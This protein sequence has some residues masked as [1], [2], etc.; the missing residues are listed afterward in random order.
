LI[1]RGA[2]ENPH[3]GDQRIAGELRKL[4]ISISASTVRRVQLR[5]R[6]GPAPRR[7]GPS[8]RQC[9]RQ[10]AASIM[11]CDFFCV[12]TMLLRRIYVLFFIELGTRR[13]HLAGLTARPTGAW[14]AQQARNLSMSGVLRQ[15]RFLIRDRDSKYTA[16]F[17]TI[18]TNE[19]LRVIRTPMRTP[20]AN[21][22][23]ERFVR[24][25]RNECLDW[26]L[27]L[28]QRQLERVLRTYI[29]QYSEQ[30]HRA[31]ELRPPTPTP[32]PP[33]GSIRR[34]DQLGGLIHEY[35]RAAT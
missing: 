18:F 12:E 3:W 35:H 4:G 14:V 10:Q 27:I 15:M 25:V 16:A 23:A 31:L 33:I 20:V 19:G 28:N 1:L 21:A 11:A 24:T 26:L 22:Y 6:L 30:P 9:L 17:D 32:R 34:H 13:V 7:D 2:R 8:W 29:E 5:A